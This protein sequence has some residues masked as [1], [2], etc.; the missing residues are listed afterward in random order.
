MAC[1]ASPVSVSE[2]VVTPPWFETT[3][4][5]GTV[6]GATVLDSCRFTMAVA[7]SGSASWRDMVCSNECGRSPAPSKPWSA[8]AAWCAVGPTAW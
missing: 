6:V 8:R 7:K 2:S 1:S 4:V 5:V 3:S